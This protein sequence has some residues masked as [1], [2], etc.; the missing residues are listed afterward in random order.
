MLLLTVITLA[1]LT[2]CATE[3]SD[4][5][6][7][8]ESIAP[9][10]PLLNATATYAGGALAVQA[11]L[12]PSVR[13]RK[14]DEP[15]APAAGG[16]PDR[17]HRSHHGDIPPSGEYLA[18]SS[19]PFEQ[20]AG[21]YSAEEVDEMYGHE[22][23]Q[24]IMPP[25][26]A[27]TFTFTNTSSA[28]TTFTITEVNSILGNYATRPEQFTLAPGQQG[29][30]DPMLSV[31]ESNFDEFEVTLAVRFGNKTETHVLHLHRTQPP[32]PSAPAN[33]PRG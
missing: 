14:A 17:G 20:G 15:S 7:L 2:A 16:M 33:P 13:L 32:P 9:P 25:R 19:A 8:R 12:G 29:S 1:S 24:H 6:K 22:N 31:F 10:Q 21:R 30:P 23:Y 27:L 18:S 26:L 4:K 3:R 11:W 5:R 28:S